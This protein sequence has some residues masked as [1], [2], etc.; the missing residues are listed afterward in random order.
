MERER[1]LQQVELTKAIWQRKIC[2]RKK[3][4]ERCRKSLVS[5]PTKISL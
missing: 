3:K 5:V 1:Q 4:N 2:G